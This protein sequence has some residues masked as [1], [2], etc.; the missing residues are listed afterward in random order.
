[1]TETLSLENKVALVTGGSRGIGRAVALELAARGAGVTGA[2][3]GCRLNN[4]A[5]V[6]TYCRRRPR[7][8]GKRLCLVSF[9]NSTGRRA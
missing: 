2:G 1:M 7:Q 6:S 4:V 8:L 3:R 9:S 5:L